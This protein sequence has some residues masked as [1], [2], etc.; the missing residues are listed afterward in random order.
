MRIFMSADTVGGVW[1][2]AVELARGLA[3]G[4]DQVMIAAMGGRL[5]ADQRRQVQDCPGL[6]VEDSD[7]AL[8]W[9]AE[10]WADLER[11]GRWLLSLAEAFRPDVVHLN[12]YAHGGLAWPAPALT[13]VHSCVYSWHAAVRGEEPGPEWRRYRALVRAGLRASAAVVAPSATMLGAAWHWYGPLPPVRL[14]H[15]GRRDGDYRPGRKQDYVLSAGRLWDEAKN[16]AALVEVAPGL[17]WPVRVA[18]EP[19]APDGGR[20]ALDKLEPLG[21]LDP[22]QMRKALAEAAIYALPARYEPFG[23]SALEAALSGC[24]LVLG[25][26]PSLR[27]L[28]DDAALFVPPDDHDALRRALRRLMDDPGLRARHGQL[29]RGRARRYDASRM[30]SEYRQLYL[31]LKEDQHSRGGGA[32][33]VHDADRDVLSLAAF[34]LESRQCPLPAGRG[35]RA[36]PSRP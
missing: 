4:G 27:E 1:H 3:A 20:A 23:L 14:I 16:V 21:R 6:L 5:S 12:H 19:R 13:V 9:M 22:G 36:D 33:E 35:R 30:V 28:W 11:A 32:R 8:E 2:Y 24:A 17:P 7:Y 26:I 34:G 10:P 29:A 31:Q 15:N 18:G 25:D